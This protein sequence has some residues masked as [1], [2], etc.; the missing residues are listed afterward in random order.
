MNT[1]KIGKKEFEYDTFVD[2]VR[3]A[4]RLKQV[5]ENLGLNPSSS[6]V[7]EKVE[8]KIKELQLDTSHFVC[9]YHKSPSYERSIQARTIKFNVSKVNQLYMDSFL[10]SLSEISR[11]QYKYTI[12]NYLEMI[13][14]QDFVKSTEQQFTEFINGK[15]NKAT[16]SNILCHLRTFMIYVVNNN[17]NGAIKKVDKQMLIYLLAAKR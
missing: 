17:I 5:N 3:Q 1:V 13:G 7:K 12:G 6:S 14:K 10:D 9:V 4:K 15:K 8:E 2:A 16:R 11:T